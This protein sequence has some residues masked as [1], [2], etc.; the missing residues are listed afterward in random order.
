MLKPNP[1]CKVCQAIETNP[2]LA[3]QIFDSSWYIKSSSTSLLDVT[4][5]YEGLFSYDSLRAHVK[6]HQFLKPHQVRSRTQT[7]IKRNAAK[8][9]TYEK[10]QVGDVWDKVISV[11]MQKLDDG[12]IEFRTSDLLKAANDKA[13]YG[14]KVKDQELAMAEM[15]AY[16]ASGEGNVEESSKY[17][18]RV[19]EGE[20]VEDYDP[21]LE[22]TADSDRRT[23][24]SRSFYQSLAGDAAS[25]GANW[26]LR[27]HD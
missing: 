17:D 19:I 9:A 6:R 22:P 13:N 10:A 15:V 7:I 20:T 24:Q 2:K 14:L 3:K 16:F 12:E 5:Q 4:K 8:V 18:R 26:V 11:G 25:S 23:H 27:E 21:T 1:Q